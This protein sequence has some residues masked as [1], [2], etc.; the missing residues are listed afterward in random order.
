MQVV[1]AV[2]ALQRP[3]PKTS[4]PPREIRL[5]PVSD[6]GR[7][8]HLQGTLDYPLR[9]QLLDTLESY[10]GIDTVLLNSGGGQVFAARGMALVL[11]KRKLNTRVE[12]VCYSACTLVF[13]A[14]ELRTMSSDST[15][16]FHRYALADYRP[17]KQLSIGS[18]LAKDQRYFESR[19]VASWFVQ[20][21]FNQLHSDIWEPSAQ[22]LHRAGVLNSRN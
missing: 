16:G 8:L 22:E 11:Q 21:M 19:S 15:L 2:A 14:G 10:P 17:G 4:A 5:L 3:P 12:G 20:D 13:M 6:G 7:T 18:E 1:D 9:E